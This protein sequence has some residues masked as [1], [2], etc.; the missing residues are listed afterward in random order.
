MAEE[1]RLEEAWNAHSY[2]D[3]ALDVDGRRV[4]LIEDGRLVEILG[5]L[6]RT[7]REQLIARYT[8]RSW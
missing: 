5:P 7:P 6:I 4:E 3:G 2:E 1:G 8:G